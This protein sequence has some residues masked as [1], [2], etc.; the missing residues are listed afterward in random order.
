[1]NRLWFGLSIIPLFTF[2]SC[3]QV[4]TISC[5]SER[6]DAPP[7]PLIP[8]ILPEVDP[9]SVSPETG[10]QQANVTSPTHLPATVITGGPDTAPL[11]QL[12]PPLPTF[13]KQDNSAWCWAASTTLVIDHLE[14]NRHL[15]QCEAVQTTLAPERKQYEDEVLSNTGKVV[16]IDCCL[17]TDQALEQNPGGSDDD[18]V[19]AS[20]AVCHT[21]FRPEWALNALGYENRF[22]IV[23][24]PL[25]RPGPRGLTWD[26]LTDQICSNRPFISVKAWDEGGTHTE[27]ITGYHYDP[28]GEMV[29]LDTHGMDRFY[30]I[31]FNE[32]Q[33]KPGDY[34]HVRDYYDIGL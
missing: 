23:R 10:R 20:K 9:A 27:A 14:P 22:Q 26:E 4:T 33:G 25:D 19:K 1:M 6:C 15:K 5:G 8:V 18:N 2:V 29:D 16:S 21:T 3:V 31:P 13:Q 12:N 17:V 24:W 30:T 11:C 34:V 32:Y 28:A 7:P